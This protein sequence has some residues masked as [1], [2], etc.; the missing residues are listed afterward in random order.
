MEEASI[1]YTVAEKYTV[2]NFR[3]VKQNCAHMG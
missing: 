2:S 1:D 3:P